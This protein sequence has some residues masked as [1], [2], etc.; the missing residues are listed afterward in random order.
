MN[1]SYYDQTLMIHLELTKPRE[2]HDEKALINFYRD[3][4]NI[5]DFIPS[6]DVEGA[7]RDFSKFSYLAL[8]I[9]N[10]MINRDKTIREGMEKRSAKVNPLSK[11]KAYSTFNII[12][13]SKLNSIPQYKNSKNIEW[14]HAW[15]VR[16]HWR[17]FSN[18]DQLGKNRHGERLE[19]GRTWVMEYEKQKDLEFKNKIRIIPNEVQNEMSKM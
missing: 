6:D 12:H 17:Y 15:K 13:L 5:R 2:G 19:K 16:G 9:F 3:R 4:S 1:H 10:D 14:S 7:F 8:C 11:K 18:N